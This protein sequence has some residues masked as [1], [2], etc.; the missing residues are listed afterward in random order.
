MLMDDKQE[1]FLEWLLTP[2]SDRV[3]GSLKALAAEMHVA[4]RTLRAWKASREFRDEWERRMAE[5]TK[6]PERI[7]M[8]YDQLFADAMDPNNKTRVQSQKL[9]LEAVGAIKSQP[10]Q[11]QVS[12]HLSELSDE[13]LDALIAEHASM[14]KARRALEVDDVER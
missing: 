4:P 5:V 6:G 12:R 10:V 3:P 7:Q 14:E 2:P 1:R 13:E 9:F 11:V 8:I